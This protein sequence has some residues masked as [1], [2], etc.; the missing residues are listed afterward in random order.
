LDEYREIRQIDKQY[1]IYNSK[2]NIL[3]KEKKAEERDIFLAWV[4]WSW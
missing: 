4:I 3:Q 2:R 1:L